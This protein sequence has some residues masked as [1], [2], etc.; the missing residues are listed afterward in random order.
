MTDQSPPIASPKLKRL[1]QRR[2]L[3]VA[4]GVL[5]LGLLIIYYWLGSSSAVSTTTESVEQEPTAVLAEPESEISLTEQ[6]QPVLIPPEI[7]EAMPTDP[8][9]AAEELDRHQDEQ[10]RM[11]EQR[12]SLKQQLADSDHLI[13]MKAEQIRLLEEELAVL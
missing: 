2:A 6:E 9:L 3:M 1:T 10:A 12:D 7:A 8:A 11:A 4:A 5:V 13:E